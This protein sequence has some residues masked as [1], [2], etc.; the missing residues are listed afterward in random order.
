MNKKVIILNGPPQSGKDFLGTIL[1]QHY[2]A[3]VIVK[4][5]EYLKN[6]THR[7]YGL[8]KVKHDYFEDVKDLPNKEFYGLTPREAYIA[9]SEQYFKPIHGK[10]F[11][12]KALVKDILESPYSLH[13]ITDGGFEEE[14]VPLINELGADNILIIHLSRVGCSFKNDSRLYINPLDVKVSKFINTESEFISDIYKC[15]IP[16][17]DIWAVNYS[18]RITSTLITNLK[19]NEIF[20]FGSNE[21]GLHGAGAAYLARKWGAK[22]KQGEGLAGQSYAL[23]TKDVHIKTLPIER[24]EFYV[25]RFISYAIQHPELIFLVTAIGCGLAGYTAK[26]IAPLFKPAKR[27]ENIHLPLEF[28]EVLAT[29]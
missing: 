14:I 2:P 9:V 1:Y 15:L 27:V 22:W 13:I 24:I 10:D 18:H 29:V 23:P 16:T 25:L 8:P 6:A 26:E 17:I 20:V 19:P 11:F 4:F 7:L 21:A 3:S 28:W 12:G 5:A